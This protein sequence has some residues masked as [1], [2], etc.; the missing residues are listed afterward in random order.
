[1]R[2]VAEYFS[3]GANRAEHQ[4]FDVLHRSPHPKIHSASLR[5]FVDLPSGEV[6]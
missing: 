1:M 3:G 6:G 2:S 4:K 5:E